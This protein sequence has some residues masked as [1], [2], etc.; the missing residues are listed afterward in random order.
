MSI[1]IENLKLAF[2]AAENPGNALQQKAY[3]RNQFDFF[4]LKSPEQTELRRHFLKKHGMPETDNL[5][6]LIREMWQQPEREFQYFGMMLTDKYIRKTE[7]GFI[8]V[9]EFM[10]TTKSWWDTVDY[11]AAGLMGAHFKRFPEQIPA[12]TEKWMASGNIWLQRSALLFQLKYKKD[13][14]IKLMFNLIKRLANENEFFI[15]KAIGW[16]L[17]EYSK[18]NPEIVVGFVETHTLKPLSKREALKRINS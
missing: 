15:R 1:F 12:Y 6:G 10:V 4:G 5:P 3:L 11:I 17:R 14:D 7:A 18:T 9:L 2:A 8:D 16:V 13:T